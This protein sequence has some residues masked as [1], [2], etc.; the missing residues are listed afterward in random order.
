MPTQ[1]D[2]SIYGSLKA[3]Q[4]ANPLQMLGSAANTI[5]AINQNRLFGQTFGARQAIGE[6][7][8]NSIDPATGQLDTNKLLANVAKDPRAAFMAGDVAQQALA[9]KQSQLGIQLSQLNLAMTH[10]K[11]MTGYFGQLLSNPNL[12]MKDVTSAAT[13]MVSEGLITPQQAAAEFANIPQDAAGL[14]QWAYNHYARYMGMQGQLAAALPK[15][16][17]VN[18]GGQ[19]VVIDTNPLTNRNVIGTRVINSMTPGEAAEPTNVLV[20][21]PDGT[22]SPSAV[23]RGQFIGMT[24]QGPVATAPALTV[25]GLTPDQATSPVQTFQNNQPGSITREQFAE[26][27]G[28]VNPLSAPSAAPPPVSTAGGL[29][30]GGAVMPSGRA[31]DQIVGPPTAAAT[32]KQAFTP[33]G[34]Q[35]GAEAA[36]NAAGTS[37]GQALGEAQKAATAFPT[38]MFQLTRALRSLENTTTGP[39]TAT[40]NSIKSFINAQNPDFVKALGLNPDVDKIKNYDEA[41][42]YLTQY[43]M[44]QAGTMGQT[45]DE[46]LATAI[47]GNANTHIS[48]L[49]AQD[50]VKA[51][52]ALERM[53]QA[54]IL[55]FDQADASP[56]DFNKY[57]TKWA[58]SVDPRAFA[59][60]VMAPKQ[61]QELLSEIKKSPAGERTKFAE[62]YNLAVKTGLLPD[63]AAPASGQ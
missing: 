61:R 12:G 3:P 44:A 53:R 6:A 50:V 62:S 54:G 13:E 40:L 33:T 28:G 41:N 45:T 51:N 2:T 8:T 16:Q 32:G 56:Q 43:A 9:R 60:D 42:K 34:P 21:N 17:V 37:S 29:E 48:N 47:T 52:M 36:A 24:H 1:V 35:L 59:L 39:G 25:K 58:S 27:H 57:M 23:T 55:A 26:G 18:A 19:Q 14:K 49:A 22:F 30:P 11:A 63:L 7:Y 20:R 15:P 10:A 46:K 4:P 31:V 38:R 5:N